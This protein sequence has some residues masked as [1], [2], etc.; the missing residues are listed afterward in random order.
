M[1]TNRYLID[2]YNRGNEDGRLT[3]QHGSVE[4]LTTMRYIQKYL[5]PGD[6]IIEIGAGTGR[7]SHALAEAGYA[8]NAVELVE[9]N[10]EIFRQNTRPGENITVTQGNAMDLSG[11]SDEAYDITLLLGPMYHLYNQD[12]KRQALREAIRVTKQGGVIFSA[13]CISDPSILDYGFKQGHVFELIEKEMLETEHFKAFSHP[14]DLFELHRKED[15]D[16]L[17]YGFPTTRLHY[18]ATDGYTNHMSEAIDNMDE[19]TFALYLKYHFTVCER[20]DMAGLTHHVLDIF[21]KA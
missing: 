12:D 19:R 11:F 16:A 5:E 17:M 8:V 18:V 7:Y 20:P 21:R 1:E 9:R 3:S 4:F 13:Y 6:K 15:I 2:Y 10:I 14:W